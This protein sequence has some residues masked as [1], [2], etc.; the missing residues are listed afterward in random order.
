MSKKGENGRWQ[1]PENLGP[2]I[3]TAR[4]DESPFMHADNTTLYFTSTGHPGYGNSDIYFT[5]RTDSGW[6]EPQNLGYP[7]NTIDH[8]GALVVSSDGRTA[9]YATDGGEGN[10]G[11][12]LFTFTLPE[13]S[14]A[15]PTTWARGR[16]ADKKTGAPLS[17]DVELANV[18]G[19]QHHRKFTTDEQGE[20]LMTLPA[21]RHY[22]FNVYKKG[23]TFFSDNILVKSSDTDTAR[24][25]DILLSPVEKGVSITLRNVF[26]DTNK[27]NVKES[28]AYEL[29]RVVTFL[30]DNPTAKIFIKG[31][32]DNIG[33]PADNLALSEKRANAV[34]DLLL[35]HGI[36]AARLSSKGFGEKNPVAGNS[37]EAGRALN[38]RTEIEVTAL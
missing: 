23:Y 30:Q 9:Y 13:Q 3:N 37:S 24:V 38:R 27:W 14:R 2:K 8:E 20:Y 1:K 4:D 18:D 29:G 25:M 19:V 28:S 26:F 32:T 22:A 15:I 17:A 10:T 35:K 5:R 36:S 11:L 21:D 12:D 31:F 16:I 6:T 34:K 7:I 33:K